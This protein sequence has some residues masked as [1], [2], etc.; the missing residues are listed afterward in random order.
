MI[1]SQATTEQQS[2]RLVD[3]EQNL[4]IKKWHMFFDDERYL[5]QSSTRQITLL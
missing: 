4:Q 5:L 1:S 2:E 3:S